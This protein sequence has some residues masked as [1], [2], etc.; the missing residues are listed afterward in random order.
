MLSV[1]CVWSIVG[2]GLLSVEWRLV[3]DGWRL[4]FGD[5]VLAVGGW[6]HEWCVAVGCVLLIGE[7][8]LLV[9]EC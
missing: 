9:V 2:G 4:V 7:R 5:C 1:G 3:V 8:W 6:C